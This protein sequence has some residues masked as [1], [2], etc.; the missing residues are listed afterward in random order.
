MQFVAANEIIPKQLM[1]TAFEALKRQYTD[2]LNGGSYRVDQ[3]TQYLLAA[4]NRTSQ[5]FAY[6]KRHHSLSARQSSS[7]LST[8]GLSLAS[9]VTNLSRG[10]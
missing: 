6:R 3:E 8:S 4:A 9:C 1:I 2:V 5:L 7:E 10:R